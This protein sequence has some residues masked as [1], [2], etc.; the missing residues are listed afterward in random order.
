MLVLPFGDTF[1]C[2]QLYV[3]KSGRVAARS[4]DGS[5]WTT[6]RKQA[7]AGAND[8][9]T[10]MTGLS[11]PLKLGG[12]AAGDYDAVTL[13]QLKA[14]SGGSGPTMNGVLNNFIGAVEWFNGSRAKLPAGYVAADGQ[15]LQRS[16]YPDLAEAVRSGFLGNCTDTEWLNGSG[17]AAYFNR[18]KYS[19]GDGTTNFRVP[20][21]N[22]MQTGSVKALFL[23]GSGSWTVGGVSQDGAPNITGTSGNTYMTGAGNPGT[24]VNGAIESTVSTANLWSPGSGAHYANDNFDASRVSPSYGR[25][26]TQE[27]RPNSVVGIWI[28]RASGSFQSANT[29]FSVLTGDATK[30]GNNTQIVGG[31]I[32]S[33]Y[34]VGG[35]SE[36]KVTLKA[37]GS[38]GGFYGARLSIMN[39]SKGGTPVNLDFTDD[40]SLNVPASLTA[41]TNISATNFFAS[42]GGGFQIPSQSWSWDY[43]YAGRAAPFRISDI[44]VTRDCIVP[45][46]SGMVAVAP[47]TVSSGYPTHALIGQYIPPT[48]AFGSLLLA[49]T[50]DGGSFARY[51]MDMS[52]QIS[53]SYRSN[54]QNAE[55]NFTYTKNAISDET[56]KHSI[57]D[58]DGRQS[59]SN[60]EAMELKTFV[61]N[62]DERGRVRRGVIAQQVRDIDP[63]YV[64]FIKP[65]EDSEGTYVLDNNPL[66]L[67]AL[68]AIQVLSK[69]LKAAQKEIAALKA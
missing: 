38:V 58:Y 21:L 25:D 47:G 32:I 13:R 22:G 68:C 36:C 29:N 23:R 46:I 48:A 27:V 45:I 34:Q 6:W 8:D 20:D 55:V 39:K 44:S 62:G 33:D 10:S 18:G 66:L 35:V 67:D 11:G 52:G 12:D 51:F 30:P 4:Y 42:Q 26:G 2:T 60:I 49:L 63:D 61:Y 14:N 64:Q 37:L 56:Y 9:I 3:T 15:L 7:N 65:T 40:G 69:D 54:S 50:G 16:A 41:G 19:H 43:I 5:T 53:G 17:G 57:R 28:I 59:L 1:S 31:E 24:T